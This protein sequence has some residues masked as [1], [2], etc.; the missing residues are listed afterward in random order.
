MLDLQC[1][2]LGYLGIQY[3]FHDEAIMVASQRHVPWLVEGDT[4]PDGV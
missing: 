1:L 2:L 3:V 4:A